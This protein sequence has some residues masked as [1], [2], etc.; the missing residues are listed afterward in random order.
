[1]TPDRPGGHPIPIVNAPSPILRELPEELP[2]ER[3]ALRPYRPGDGAQVWEAIQE[4]LPELRPWMP[5]AH[6]HIP[7]T[8]TEEVIRRFAAQ[9]VLRQHLIVGIWHRETG[10][11]LGSTGLH[12]I[13]WEIPWFELGYWVR[14]SEERKGYVTEAGR[15]LMRFAFETLGANRL[16]VR[17]DTRNE[18]SIAVARRLGFTLEGTRRCDSR[19]PAGELRDTL[20]FSLTPGE[21]G[22]LGS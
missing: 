8:E 4:S 17:C 13:D 7:P 12:V 2:G 9:W 20:I 15:L 21:Y 22:R 6:D 18:R 3:V 11:F 5:W 1:M 16:E 19:T 14:T 10:R